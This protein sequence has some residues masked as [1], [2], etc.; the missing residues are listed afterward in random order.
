[1]EQIIPAAIMFIMTFIVC[2]LFLI[3]SRFKFG[4]SLMRFYWCGF[5]YF[6]ALIG[7]VAGGAE[8]LKIL[9]WQVDH[10]SVAIL[11]GIMSAY[12]LFVVFAWFRL[13][14]AA[15]FKTLPKKT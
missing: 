14:G 3:P 5:W 15:V 11:A 4:S 1:M 12:I 2:V 10:Q 9:G 6:L 7:F 8:V 13:V